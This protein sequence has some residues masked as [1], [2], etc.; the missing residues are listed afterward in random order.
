MVTTTTPAAREKLTTLEFSTFSRHP[1]TLL[2]Y[3]AKAHQYRADYV[4]PARVPLII[5]SGANLPLGPA[6]IPVSG[7]DRSGRFGGTAPVIAA[8]APGPIGGGGG[9]GV[10]DPGARLRN[11]L[12]GI[13]PMRGRVLPDD[14]SFFEWEIVD[15][16]SS[17]TTTIRQTRKMPACWQLR[18]EVPLNARLEVELRI[19][20]ADGKVTST[21]GRYRLVDKVVVSIGDSYASGEGLPDGQAVR[22]AS[23]L[24][25]CEQATLAAIA[26]KIAQELNGLGPVG[27]VIEDVLRG[28]VNTGAK[29]VDVLDVVTGGWLFGGG[30]SI[31]PR[32]AAWAEPHAHRSWLSAPSTA[33]RQIGSVGQGQA[34]TITFLSFARSGSRI[35]KGLLAG[36]TGKRDEWIGRIGQI[37]EAR[38]TLA[39]RKVDALLISIGGNDVGFSDLRDLVTGDFFGDDQGNLDSFVA[40]KLAFVKGTAA[41]QDNLR[42]R[43][44]RL[45]SA[46]KV[47]DPAHVIVTGYPVDL[48]SKVV[49][50]KVV[51]SGGCGVFQ[52]DLLDLDITLQD[53]QGL[54]T[55]GTALNA[56]LA[57][58]CAEFGWTFIDVT[59]AF[60][61]HGYCASGT[62]FVGHEESCKTQG[63][64]D[65]VLHPN[66]AGIKVYADKTAS[67]LRDKLFN[68]FTLPTPDEPLTQ[69]PGRINS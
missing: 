26:A 23:Q 42:N 35:D 20:W 54:R 13:K 1:A 67:V 30:G 59:A 58:I 65:G 22:T 64:L 14:L 17:F 31:T 38:R 57:A 56:A 6:V 3:D 16:R 40:S 66:R 68:S 4:R 7:F 36:R 69:H 18:T 9:G 47:L 63:D 29:V 19:G 61:G 25:A 48:F 33:V 27:D 11:E 44:N 49:G 50:G 55:I 51:T 52:N 46:V 32:P 10:T 5:D 53:A 62:F 28:I 2:G 39:G 34:R 60:A 8:A 12:A 24:L 43:F 41:G 37:E 45:R 21:T 15:T